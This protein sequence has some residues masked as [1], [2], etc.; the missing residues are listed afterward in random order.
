MRMIL[1]EA[2]ALAVLQSCT[3]TETPAASKVERGPSGAAPSGSAAVAA[4]RPRF[5]DLVR[6][7]GS[8]L[9]RAAVEA[10][11][12]RIWAKSHR[13]WIHERRSASAPKLGYLRAGGSAPTS[14]KAAGTEGCPGG[15][16][17]IE[18]EGFVCGGRSAT[19]DASDPV[20]ALTRAYPPD[21]TQKLPYVYGSVRKP[22]PVYQRLPTGEEQSKVDQRQR[23]KRSK[24][25]EHPVDEQRRQVQAEHTKDVKRPDGAMQTRPLRT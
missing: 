18:P 6:L 17:P 7:D 11:E 8:S 3:R 21:A 13:A 9:P 22:G 23:V 25:A 10:S 20:V 16:Y 5:P 1:A 12:G 15:W 14:G 4:R 2:V 19:L 24:S